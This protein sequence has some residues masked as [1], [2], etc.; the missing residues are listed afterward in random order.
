MPFSI[1]TYGGELIQGVL[2]AVDP[3]GA[4]FDKVSTGE[5]VYFL[6]REIRRVDPSR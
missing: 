6:F 5:Q 2:L 1:E 3:K 4:T